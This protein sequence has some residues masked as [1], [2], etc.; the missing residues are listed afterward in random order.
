[1][2]IHYYSRPTTPA[3]Y[4]ALAAK[5]TLFALG[6]LILIFLLMHTLGVE[7]PGLL[8]I[9]YIGLQPVAD[10]IFYAAGLQQLSPMAQS[11]YTIFLLMFIPALVNGGHML[12]LKLEQLRVLD[13]AYGPVKRPEHMAWFIASFTFLF[14][15][16]AVRS[17][18][19]AIPDPLMRITADAARLVFILAGGLA[20]LSTLI[21]GWQLRSSWLKSPDAIKLPGSKPRKGS[22]KAKPSHL[23][24]A[25]DNTTP[26]KAAGQPLH[27]AEYD[28]GIYIALTAE[29]VQACGRQENLPDAAKLHENMSML[30][31]AAQLTRSGQFSHP[32]LQDLCERA[33]ALLAAGQLHHLPDLQAAMA[34]YKR[35][36]PAKLTAI[37]AEF[38]KL[39]ENQ[40]VYRHLT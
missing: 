25:I 16:V 28:M 29:I 18:E 4:F 34:L 26:A 37:A 21:I 6:G 36:D 10:R 24:V 8:K 19:L 7:N 9:F 3:G 14:I 12:R 11:E 15:C 20:C 17:L 39:L 31:K 2:I 23:K 27:L 1:M 5:S 33:C 13:E 30:Q 35:A 22:G 38:K 32:D 40:P